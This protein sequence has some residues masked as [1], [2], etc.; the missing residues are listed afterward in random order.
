[1]NDA[2]GGNIP[3]AITFGRYPGYIRAAALDGS[4]TFNIGDAWEGM[5]ARADSFGG[6]GPGS[7]IS[8]RNMQFL[9]N[10]IARSS[11]IRLSS[12]PLDPANA[13]SAFLDEINYLQKAGYT[14]QGNRMVP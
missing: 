12:D 9:D 11:E 2:L 1:V 10:A 14:L 3:N 7:E 8:I 5:A 6:T 4:R 13:G